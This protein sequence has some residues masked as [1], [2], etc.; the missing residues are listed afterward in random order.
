[1]LQPFSVADATLQWFRRYV[2]ASFPLRDPELDKQRELLIDAGLLWAEPYVALARPGNPGPKLADLSGLLAPATLAVPWGFE[3]LYQHQ[4]QAIDRLASQPGHDPR[5]TLV[6]SGTGSGKT[7]AFLI[8]VVDACLRDPSPGIK[9]VVVYPMNALANDQLKRLRQLLADTPVTFGRYTGDAPETDAGDSRRQG[10]PEDAPENMR[11]SR[12]AMREQPPSILL[13]NYTMLEYLL[14]RGKDEELFRHGPPRYLIV[15]EIHLFGGVLGAEVGA[16][17]RRFRQH[18]DPDSR[19]ICMVGTS[20]TAGSDTEAD[21][22]RRFAERFFG[23]PFEPEALI[24]ETPAPFADPGPTAP[25][26]PTLTPEL[27]TAATDTAGLAA[28]AKATFGVELPSDDTFAGQLGAVI[29]RYTTVSAVE[30]ALARPASLGSAARALADLSERSGV[31]EDACLLE[32]QAVVLLGAAARV[33][34]MGEDE[35]Q[36]RFRPRVHQVLRSLAGLWRCTDPADGTLRSPDGGRCD[37]G[38]FTLPLASC[39]TC[40]E[41]YWSSPAPTRNLDDIAQVVAVEYERNDPAV[42]LADPARLTDLVGEDED[43]NLV[44]W[45]DSRLCPHCGGFVTGPRPI[46]HARNCPRPHFDGVAVLAST[47]D[48]HCPAC[49]SQGAR[50]RPILLPLQGSAAA[51]VAVVANGLSN[52]LRTRTG[53]AGGR[54][55]IF[56]DSRQNAA[57]QAGY[58][59][60]QGARVAIRQ[61]IAS[62]VDGEAG[63]LTLPATSSRVAGQVLDDPATLRRWLVGEAARDFAEVSGPDYVPSP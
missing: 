50:N 14:L 22:L 27:L 61:L 63:Q 43:G 28:L 18:T 32:A 36:P 16:L 39:R 37:C 23:A 40:G 9:A 21:E 19:G 60:D 35:P 3:R 17:L 29:D 55:L 42:F 57:Q 25:T 15:D 30:R 56:A 12:M 58:S 46:S 53:E 41:A 45:R 10:R 1:M 38:A 5:N 8:P 4:R 51:S 24:A 7:E 33:P 26:L 31:D 2:R 59:D 48:I 52:D 49:G 47:D 62:S 34:A 13:T 54:L 11:W 20:A 6:L 44:V